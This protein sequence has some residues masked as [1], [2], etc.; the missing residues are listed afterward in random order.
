MSL[1]EKTTKT[2][3]PAVYTPASQNKLQRRPGEGFFDRQGGS[4]FFKSPIQ[5]KLSVNT[6]GDAHEQEADAVADKVMR[7]P[8]PATTTIAPSPAREELQKKEEDKKE[9]DRM[10]IGSVDAAP[11]MRRFD[12]WERDPMLT[13]EEDGAP[14]A[15]HGIGRKDEE[16]NMITGETDPAPLQR[17]EEEEKI[18]AKGEG[19][20]E[21]QPSFEQGLQSAKGGGSPLPDGVK[22]HMESGIGADF[23]NVRVHTGTQAAQLSSSIQAQAFTHGRDIYFNEGKYNPGTDSGKH[24]LA[25]E[26]TH[27]V[28][29][30]AAAQTSQ[31]VQRQPDPD[32]GKTY[33]IVIP[34]GAKLNGKLIETD[35]ELDTYAEIQIFGHDRPDITWKPIGADRVKALVQNGGTINYNLNQAHYGTGNEDKGA[36]NGTGKDNGT[37]GPSADQAAKAEL[38]KK[39][40][41]LSPAVKE[42]IR[43]TQNTPPADYE[44]LLEVVTLLEQMSLADLED[45]KSQ[46]SAATTDPAVM[47]KSVM[48]FLR[49]KEERKL[50][51]EKKETIRTKLYGLENLYME[52]KRLKDFKVIV[53]KSAQQM[54]MEDPGEVLKRDREQKNGWN[55]LAR[56]LGEN[57]FG[58]PDGTG[59]IAAFEKYIEEYELAFR[60]ETLAI[61]ETHLQ[62]YRHVLYEEE[63]KI[64]D[65]VYLTSLYN[66]LSASGA[67][68]HYDNSSR[69]NRNASMIM[70]DG[71]T[72][73]PSDRQMKREMRENAQREKGLGDAAVAALPSALV[74]EPGFDKEAFAEVDS[75]A[76][77]KTFLQKYIAGKREDVNKTWAN[78]NEDEG[79]QS[80]TLDNLFNTSKQTQGATG[81]NIYEQ[82]VNDK[83]GELVF[84][85]II[86]GIA[87]AVFAI[88]L[89]LL[90]GGT[91]TIAVLAATGTLALSGYVVYEEIQ[92]YRDKLAA[93][94]VGL[95]SEEPSLV[96]II[97][98]IAGA[99][100]DAAALAKVAKAG[101]AL[102]KSA[103]TAEDLLQ[104]ENDLKKIA[105]LSETVRLKMVQ[106]AAEELK[107]RQLVK[108]I[109]DTGKGAKAFIKA[110]GPDF[111]KLVA[112]GYHLAKKGIL[113]FGTYLAELKAAGVINNIKKLS[114]QEKV[115]LKDAFETAKSLTH[116]NGAIAA[117]IEQAIKAGNFSKLEQLANGIK[118]VS[119]KTE[120]AFVGSMNQGKVLSAPKGKR[121][122][123]ETYLRP[124]YIAEHLSQ[125]DEG[126]VRF[127][128]RSAY[129]KYGTLGPD[130]G[131]VLPKKE[132]D[133]VLAE[134]KGDIK[135]IEVKL[136]LPEG[137]LGDD[138]VMIVL[139]ERK[140]CTSLSLPS[141][142]ENGA[143][144][145]WLP[146]GYTSG[147][148]PEA[149]MNFST[150]PVFKEIKIK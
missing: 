139:M 6:P 48:D 106:S 137:Y 100:L 149:V 28:Q 56:A 94:H 108:G 52:Y 31:T 23:S 107:A 122:L 150:K 40:D 120:G 145:F 114:A 102:S 65:D 30:G 38:K 10:Q 125:F 19:V 39:L 103:G 82:I 29:Q 89:G 35:A 69:S 64:N 32:P 92:G 141:G 146:G 90:T 131:F 1:S 144:E 134:S 8:Q 20:P 112:A 97:I 84:D 147:G 70:D 126:V 13:G 143:N 109:F 60:K 140:D 45:Y 121:P 18:Q 41:N 119:Q 9:E 116:T 16:D 66:K 59:S 49:K 3:A 86:H 26:L 14:L 51:G 68:Q 93:Y 24:L 43:F 85:E 61:A 58:N 77:L 98:A 72:Y 129:K 21:V 62:R 5:A 96:W 7:M 87:I 81:G 22:Q 123:P 17:R 2:T 46:V 37:G 75:K 83:A 71:K 25:H 91:G 53:P 132:L 127:T 133:K 74:N 36:G 63:N 118:I 50:A 76:A 104:F 115:I 33:K 79:L 135:L 55:A 42:L 101:L 47:K 80:Y 99:V 27:T 4:A 95:S 148:T 136:G 142:N 44:A 12:E 110:A 34:K 57:G 117:D 130:G 67:R 73:L 105:E 124:D 88:A 111:A 78:I 138:D 15:R 113:D 54:D 11:L 128:S